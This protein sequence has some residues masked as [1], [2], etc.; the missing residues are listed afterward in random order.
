MRT[1]QGVRAGLLISGLA[2]GLFGAWSLVRLGLSNLW[3]VLWLAGGVLANDGLLAGLSLA[4]V[5]VGLRVLP[6]WVRAPGA[7][8]II[9]LGSVTVMA[10]PG[11]GRFGAL[12]D[13][14]SLLDRSYGMGWLV[15]AGIV[16]VGVTAASAVVR[17]REAAQVD[18]EDG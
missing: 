11:L 3:T 8:G 5:V 16:A 7:V 13:N 10:I 6:G 17:G 9:V 4:V 2:L 12:R 14:P 15:V 1:Q 18:S